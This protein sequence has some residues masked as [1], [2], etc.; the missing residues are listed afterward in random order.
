L[1]KTI[2]RVMII[3]L[4]LCEGSWTLLPQMSLLEKSD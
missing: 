4:Q 1:R 2:T 3:I